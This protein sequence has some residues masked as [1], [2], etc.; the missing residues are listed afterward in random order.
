MPGKPLTFSQ[1]ARLKA[2]GASRNLGQVLEE[3]Q[4]FEL[5]SSL[6]WSEKLGLKATSYLPKNWSVGH[7]K[8]SDNT[9]IKMSTMSNQDFILCFQKHRVQTELWEMIWILS[10]RFRGTDLLELF[11]WVISLMFKFNRIARIY[12]GG[13]QVSRSKN[14]CINEVQVRI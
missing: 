3:Q 14:L 12:I 7:W 2:P 8:K 4:Q 6:K 13:L 1:T 5:T 10:A 9:H 11:T